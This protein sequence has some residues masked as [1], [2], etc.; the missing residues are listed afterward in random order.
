MPKMWLLLETKGNNLGISTWKD[1]ITNPSRTC[2]NENVKKIE[3]FNKK[4]KLFY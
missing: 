3:I 4:N 1:R 2:K